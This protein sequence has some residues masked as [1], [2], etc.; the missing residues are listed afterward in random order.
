[1][2]RLGRHY[3]DVSDNIR[4]FMRQGVVIKTIINGMTFDSSTKDPMTQAVRDALIGFIASLSQGQA[5]ANKEAHRAGI[6]KS[7]PAPRNLP[8]T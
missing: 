1:M 4:A 5:E 6:V 2:D 3:E 8:R 7:R